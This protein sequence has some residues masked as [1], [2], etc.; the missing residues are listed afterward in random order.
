M[1]FRESIKLDSLI[2]E[3]LASF[4][5]I[6]LSKLELEKRSMALQVMI[7]ARNELDEIANMKQS[8]TT[9]TGRDIRREVRRLACV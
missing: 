4:T 6:D 1:R 3:R 7:R 2:D 8:S 5:R 9:T